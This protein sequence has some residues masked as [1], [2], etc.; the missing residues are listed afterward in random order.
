MF[1]RKEDYIGDFKEVARRNIVLILILVLAALVWIWVFSSAAS[2]FISDGERPFRASWGGTGQFQLFGL[3]IYFNF[4]GYVDYDYY[5]YTWGEQFL[6]GI[7]PYSNIFDR[8]IVGN[9]IYDTPYFFPPLYVYLCAIGLVLPI[10]PFGIG[11]LLTL[12]G[13]LTAFPVY[14][15]SAYIS[16]NRRVAEISVFT[17]LFNP[18]V[19]FHTVFKWLNPAPFVFFM[20]LSFYLLM[21]GRRVSGTLAMVT[22][23]LFKQ[24]A[25]FLLIPLIIILIKKHEVK[26]PEGEVETTRPLRAVFDLKNFSKM[27]GLAVIYV[28]AV[29][30]PFLFEVKNYLHYI[31]EVPGG[32]LLTN[33][34]TLP[35]LSQPITPAAFLIFFGAPIELVDFVNKATYYSV[36]LTISILIILPFMLKQVTSN[37]TPTNFWR[38]MLFLTLLLMLSV[39]IFSPRGI[40][41]YY[42]VALIPFFSIQPVSS[43]IT[44]KIERSRASVYMILNPIL[45][46]LL[47]IIPGRYV[48]IGIVA[49]ILLGY[50]L[51]EAFSFVVEALTHRFDSF[52][53]RL[54]ISLK[55]DSEKFA[56]NESTIIPES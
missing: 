37:N 18:I 46:G 44:T 54:R 5:Y 19:L 23:A 41:K 11:F 30:L 2:Q 56:T 29:S 52:F 6:R 28:V 51:H 34:T 3:T 22:A 40:Y 48:Y 49:L 20:M 39:H 1:P 27:A 33:L 21:K 10:D 32:V 35:D 47:I 16:N 45:L 15:I 13:Y 7:A 50:V 12:F 42:F 53:K 14:G 9:G 36:F 31:F 24:M 4:E 8:S 55:I 26:I 38:R 43:V 17:Y 25:F